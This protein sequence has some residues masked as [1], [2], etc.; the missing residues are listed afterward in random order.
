MLKL[1]IPSREKLGTQRS[2]IVII[3]QVAISLVSGGMKQ[4]R[5]KLKTQHLLLVTF[6]ILYA[7]SIQESS[8]IIR[9]GI[10]AQPANISFKKSWYTR[11]SHQTLH[12]SQ[13]TTRQREFW[14]SMSGDDDGFFTVHT[15]FGS[16]LFLNNNK[17]IIIQ[18]CCHISPVQSITK[19]AD[20]V[21]VATGKGGKSS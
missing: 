18:V 13:P 19:P 21:S 4:R 3:T 16:L 2:S 12:V 1:E 5:P 8:H 6:H 7:S 17:F 11:H 14:W 9:S 20:C 10:F 15:R